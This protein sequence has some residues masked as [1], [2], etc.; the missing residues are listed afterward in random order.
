MFIPF[1]KVYITGK[2]IEYINQVFLSGKLSGGGEFTKKCE[3]FLRYRYNF[4]KVIM[5]SSCTDALEMASLLADIKPGDEV[6][7]PS[8][9]FV[10]TANA[11][12]LRGAKIVFA[13]SGEKNP[14]IDADKIECLITNKTKAIVV[15][16]YGGIACD[17]DKIIDSAN[18]NNLIVIEDMA[19]GIDCYYKGKPLGSIGTLAS[20]SF[21]DTKNITSGEGGMLIIND[22]NLI[23]KAEI[24]RDKGTNMAKFF[25]GEIDKYLWVGL[26][27]S[28]TPSEVTAAIL[29]S[30]LE[31][32]DEIQKR[33][34]N[35][36]N[37]Y[38]NLLKPLHDSGKIELSYLPDYAT[39][40]GHIF[41][42]TCRSEI[43]R[44]SLIDFLKKNRIISAFHYLS[45]HK[46]PFNKNASQMDL[47]NS[48]RFTKC[49]L[50]L[51]IYY[52]LKDSEIEYVCSKVIE[53]FRSE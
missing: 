7:I 1:N 21:H 32:L 53:Y 6:I 8:Y 4:K 33:R 5:T 47:P 15:V 30:Q 16:H 49:L 2:E 36:W 42:L 46:S 40:N 41:Y 45:L 17:M 38:Y 25:R 14:N 18:K 9:T 10:S 26:G 13:D 31:H 27:S 12:M 3:E 22:E 20:L 24:I 50:R 35:I 52:E 11:F 37:S 19:H 34:V 23:E 51:P 48:E 29:Y 39:N 44:K 28:F 43:E